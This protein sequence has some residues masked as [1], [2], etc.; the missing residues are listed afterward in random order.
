MCDE[1]LGGEVKSSAI[2]HLLST[3]NN[4]LVIKPWVLHLYVIEMQSY[5]KVEAGI[6]TQLGQAVFIGTVTLIGTAPGQAM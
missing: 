5:S 1:E 3:Y 2:L 4:I 6:R